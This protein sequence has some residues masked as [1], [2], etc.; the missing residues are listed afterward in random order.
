MTATV[1]ETEPEAEPRTRKRPASHPCGWCAP[2]FGQSG[3]RD[4]GH[5]CKGTYRNGVPATVS[6]DRL[7]RCPCAEAGHQGRPA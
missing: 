6:P 4:R 3:C 5:L 1:T 2:A 7:W